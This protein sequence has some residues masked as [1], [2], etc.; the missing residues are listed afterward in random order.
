LL[1]ASLSDSTWKQYNAVHRKWTDFCNKTKADQ[2]K[3][4][5]VNILQFL[6][7][8]YSSGLGYVAINTARSALST[9]LGSVEGYPIGQHPLINRLLKGV[10]R[11]RPPSSKY[12]F[13][14]DVSQVLQLFKHWESDCNLSLKLLTLKTVGLLALCTAQRVQTL[15]SLTRS[16]IHFSS[17]DLVIRVSSRL[18]TTKPGEGLIINLKKYSEEKLCIYSCLRHYMERTSNLSTSDF[19]LVC[20]QSPYKKA[21]EQTISRWLKELLSLA[22]IDITLFSSHSFRHASTS[23]AVDI[24]VNIDTIFKTAGWTESSKVFGKFYKRP[25]L[26]KDFCTSILSSS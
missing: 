12:K 24:G 2:W 4:S 22:G 16:N 23:K 17:S 8:I 6:T 11:L 3:P 7:E 19:L 5:V 25:I 18:K 15:A 26:D 20:H 9:I 21:T 13:V 10:S 1:N 14:W